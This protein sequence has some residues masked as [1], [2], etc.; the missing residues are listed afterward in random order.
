MFKDTEFKRTIGMGVSYLIL[1][2]T[3]WDFAHNDNP[4][5]FVAGFVVMALIRLAYKF[6]SDERKNIH[7]DALLTDVYARILVLEDGLKKLEYKSNSDYNNVLELWE[8]VD[9]FTGTD[10]YGNSKN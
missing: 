8:R 1:F 2:V 10:R 9:K 7:R 6:A 5:I 4:L 3:L